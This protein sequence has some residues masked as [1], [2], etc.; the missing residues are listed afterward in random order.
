VSFDEPGIYYL[1]IELHG[2]EYSKVLP[3]IVVAEYKDGDV[4]AIETGDSSL[5]LLLSAK[6]R[7]NTETQRDVWESKIG[8]TTVSARFSGFNWDTNG[9]ITDAQG[10]TA[11]HLTNGAK[12]VIPYSPFAPDASNNGAEKTGRTIELDFKISNIRD[13]SKPCITC[14]SSGY[15]DDNGVQVENINTGIQIYG[16][17][18]QMNSTAEKS[19]YDDMSGW[20]T[21]FKEGNR[22]HL[23]YV[24]NSLSD[25]PA[26]IFYT[27]LNGVTSSLS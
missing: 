3:P 4:P 23:T 11:L 13:L 6:N 25:N 9:W 2:T 17:K 10:A 7:S 22:V 19:N 5:R 24:I 27:F 21:M 12:V 20:T 1:T 18:S 15:I 8:S 14:K 26:R 16:N